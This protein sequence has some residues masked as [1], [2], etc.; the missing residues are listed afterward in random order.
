MKTF[1]DVLHALVYSIPAL[2]IGMMIHAHGLSGD[3]QLD[4]FLRWACYFSA[5][6]IFS[7]KLSS[8]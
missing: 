3:E 4:M 6:Y 7:N 5:G 1:L 8:H 2:V